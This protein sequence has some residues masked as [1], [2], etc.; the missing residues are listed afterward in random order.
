MR[1]APKEMPLILC[2]WPAMSEAD[3]GGT[4]VGVEPSHQYSIPFCCHVAAEGRSDRMVSD[5]EVHMK[6]RRGMEFLHAEKMAPN[7][8]H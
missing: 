7:D 8:V 4:V 3:G 5:M 6:Q 2:C 1:A